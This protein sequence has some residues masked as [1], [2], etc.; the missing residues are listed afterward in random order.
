M[1]EESEEYTKVYFEFF[2]DILDEDYVES[3][4]AAVVDETEGLYKLKNIPFFVKGYS[5]EDTVYAELEDDRLVV[6]G[7]VEESGNSTLQIICFK[8]E[9]AEQIQKRLEEFGCAWEGSHLPGYFSVDVS[10]DLDYE[11]IREYLVDLEEKEILSY[12]EACLAHKE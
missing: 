10:A 9:S 5:S 12:R 8:E 2:N 3:V 1:E 7:L 11:P 6:K 4:W